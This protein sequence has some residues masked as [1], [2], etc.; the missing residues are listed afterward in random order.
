MN[1]MKFL[2]GKYPELY[3]KYKADDEKR[4]GKQEWTIQDQ[5]DTGNKKNKGKNKGITK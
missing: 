2:K 4:K 1:Y 5:I 3:A